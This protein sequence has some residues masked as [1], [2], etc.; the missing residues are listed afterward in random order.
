MWIEL[1]K[2]VGEHKAGKFLEVKDDVGG[3]YV[4]AGMA[5]D[6]GDGPDTIIFKRA[7]DRYQET[8]Q[9]FVQATAARLE[10]VTADLARRPI[11]RAAGGD[12]A[13]A[14]YEFSG[15]ITPGESEAGEHGQFARRIPGDF[16]IPL[17][18]P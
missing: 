17:I 16:Y 6:G 3:A 15:S 5:R 11:V 12:G 2:D 9:G 13:A 10:A 18:A 8:L 14:G 1:I 4:T 7:M